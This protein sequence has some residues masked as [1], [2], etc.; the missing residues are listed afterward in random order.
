[1][2]EYMSQK[3]VSM[4]YVCCI[5]IQCVRLCVLVHVCV[6]VCVNI[7]VRVCICVYELMTIWVYGYMGVCVGGVVH[8]SKRATE[9]IQVFM[10]SGILDDYENIKSLYAIIFICGNFN[11]STKKWS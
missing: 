8:H 10:T 5:Y 2:D 3:Y 1:M 6:C 9:T 11:L 7:Y 4:L